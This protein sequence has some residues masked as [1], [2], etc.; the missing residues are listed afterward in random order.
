MPWSRSRSRT[1]IAAQLHLFST[2]TSALQARARA[3]MAC[4]SLGSPGC[5]RGC[6][7]KL[8]SRRRVLCSEPLGRYGIALNTSLTFALT[9]APA[10]QSAELE[11][12]L[13]DK[14]TLQLCRRLL[15]L[16]TGEPYAC[17]HE[18]T[19]APVTHP[20][21]VA[22]RRCTHK[23]PPNNATI[24]GGLS[25]TAR[26][27]LCSKCAF[28]NTSHRRLNP[29]RGFLHASSSRGMPVPS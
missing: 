5:P 14:Y 11:A 21:P 8:R 28:L 19:C 6:S 2:Q 24:A 18:Y 1:C 26:S 20:S 15:A 12:V 3:R 16:T 23:P 13:E 27:A 29:L 22:C 17:S 10:T 25:V 4:M 9:A 7:S